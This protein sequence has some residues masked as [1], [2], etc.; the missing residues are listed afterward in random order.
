[1]RK[2]L[3]LILAA[4][5]LVAQQPT[6]VDARLAAQN[7]LFQDYWETTLKLNPTLAT[8]VG[9]YRYND[10]LGDYSL[11][12]VARRHETSASFLGRIKA[13][14]TDG[15]S[16]EDRT[17][18]DLLQRTLQEQ[19]DDYDLKEYEMPLTAMGGVHTQLAD[20]PNSMPLDSVKHYED[21]IAR[22]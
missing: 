20:L 9:D 14:A 15:F 18:H 5:P 2:L 13:I 4:F 10:K 21:Y 3:F 1:M 12:S 22:L 8:N 7:A 11:A 19:I 17:S 16:E 6:P